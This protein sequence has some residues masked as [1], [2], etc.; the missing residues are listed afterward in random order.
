MDARTLESERDVIPHDAPPV[1]L[2]PKCRDHRRAPADETAEGKGNRDARSRHD[3][4][5]SR[6]EHEVAL[7]ADAE[8]QR[9]DPHW[10]GRARQDEPFAG[11]AVVFDFG[12]YA[13]PREPFGIPDVDFEGCLLGP[14]E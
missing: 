12:E 13:D 3:Q 7:R 9:S 4:I 8:P 10:H 5:T 6:A 11:A 2:K 1:A 14:A